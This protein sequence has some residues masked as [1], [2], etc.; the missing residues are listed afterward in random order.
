[1]HVEDREKC[2]YLSLPSRVFLGP[3]WH[4][5]ICLLA[6]ACTCRAQ[7][8]RQTR[9]WCCLVGCEHGQAVI[10]LPWISDIDEVSDSAPVCILGIS[11]LCCGRTIGPVSGSA[12][13]FWWWA[14]YSGRLCL[15]WSKQQR[16]RERGKR[17]VELSCRFLYTSQRCTWAE[18]QTVEIDNCHQARFKC[19]C[20]MIQGAYWKL[21]HATCSVCVCMCPIDCVFYIKRRIEGIKVQEKERLLCLRLSWKESIQIKHRKG[22]KDI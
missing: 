4:V 17:Q 6:A 5:A 3:S 7:R 8:K 9:F 16:R 1:M 11:R 12:A 13:C 19:R 21:C 2:G 22:S 20:R 15:P 10:A 18:V 14:T